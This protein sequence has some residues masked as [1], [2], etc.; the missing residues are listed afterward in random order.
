G[1]LVRP[2]RVA[3]NLEIVLRVGARPR[4]GPDVNELHHA[5]H[6]QQADEFLDC[7]GRVSNRE[8][9]LLQVRHLTPCPLSLCRSFTTRSAMETQRAP[10]KGNRDEKLPLA[11]RSSEILSIR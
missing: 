3:Q 7:A 11:C 9:G 2:Q 6:F 8:K 1:N 4:H 10:S 5:G